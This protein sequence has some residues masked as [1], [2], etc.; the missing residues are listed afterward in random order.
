MPVLGVP[1]KSHSSSLNEAYADMVRRRAVRDGLTRPE[2][3][4]EPQAETKVKKTAA[5][6]TTAKKA[7]AQADTAVETQA[8]T[9]TT[10]ARRARRRRAPV[11]RPP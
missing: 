5:K 6:A 1:V 9:R 7:A 3:P 4:Q 11:E 2:Q 8:P 10:P